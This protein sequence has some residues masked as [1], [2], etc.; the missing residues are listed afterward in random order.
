M[1]AFEIVALAAAMGLSA[2]APCQSTCM[3][4]GVIPVGD[5]VYNLQMNEF[6]SAKQECVRT[7]GVGFVITKASFN[8]A[9]DGSPGTYTSLY[10]G[11]HWG[12]CTKSNPFPIQESN[13]ASIATSVTLTQ[14][15]GSSHDTAYDI[16]FNQTS[17][18]KGQPNGAEVMIWLDHQGSIQ[19]F[20]SQTG[21]VTIAGAQYDVW[22]GNKAS[23]KIVSYVA[24]N[25]VSAVTNLDLLPFFEDAASRGSLERSWW[26]VDVEFGF[27]IWTGGKGLG[28]SG[29]SVN[30][31]GKSDVDADPS[32]VGERRGDSISG[33]TSNHRL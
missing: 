18:L 31:K 17:T 6:N 25:P 14:P 1:R 29:F 8:N 3:R 21:S 11:C 27:E 4:F 10:R 5:G 22:T 23:W 20:G 12:A 15:S 28:A 19:P 13:I 2:V 30:A 9:T 32:P 33:S 26:L 16:W 7:D 24:T